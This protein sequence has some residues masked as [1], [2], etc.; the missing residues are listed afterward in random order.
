MW[1]SYRLFQSIS[2]WVNQKNS[3]LVIW[4]S[5][6]GQ[7]KHLTL[8]VNNNIITI[9]IIWI[10]FFLGQSKIQYWSSDS[11]CW[12]NQNIWHWLLIIISRLF[13]LISWLLHFIS[14]LIRFIW[15]LFVQSIE[16]FDTGHPIQF[17]LIGIT[18]SSSFDT[19]ACNW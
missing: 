14:W 17:I 19:I 4:F 13:H 5:L 11:V 3:I 2:S 6:L 18:H 16:T 7:S 8:I 15:W 12:V 1:L 9:Q 10:N